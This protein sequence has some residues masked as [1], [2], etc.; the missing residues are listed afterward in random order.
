MVIYL[1][2]P[3]HG[4]KVAISEEEAS[5]DCLNG[6]KRTTLAAL[7]IPEELEE[8]EEINNHDKDGFV[9]IEAL[10]DQWQATF[11]KVPHHRKS[12]ETLRKELGLSGHDDSAG[13]N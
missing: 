13:R 5:A 1:S 4:T 2:H 10:R 7:M 9:G 8:K 11:G 12:A 3:Q 6:W